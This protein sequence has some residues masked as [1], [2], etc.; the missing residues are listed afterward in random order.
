VVIS[1]LLILLVNCALHNQSLPAAQPVATALTQIIA[2]PTV[3][4]ASTPIPESTVLPAATPIP[5]TPTYAAVAPV[6][7]TFYQDPQWVEGMRQQMQRTDLNPEQ[8]RGIEEKL[9]M[10]DQEAILAATAA[11]MPTLV[12]SGPPTPNPFEPT[13]PPLPRGIL[14]GGGDSFSSSDFIVQNMWQD[15]IDGIWV[16]IHAGANGD[17]HTQG[18]L[19]V[20]WRLPTGIQGGRY[21]TPQKSGSIRIIAVKNMLVSVVAQ[22]GSTYTFDLTKQTWVP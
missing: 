2:E 11:V 21:P 17:D 10:M 14:E 18:A 9:W 8:R 12:P 19:S 7:A 1:S 15:Q 20:V 13:L 4:P 6:A 3:L 5:P 22:D 16:M